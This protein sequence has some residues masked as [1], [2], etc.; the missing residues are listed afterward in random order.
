MAVAT[1]LLFLIKFFIFFGVWV[2]WLLANGLKCFIWCCALLIIP[3]T[4]L[5]MNVQGLSMFGGLSVP[6]L[7]W[8]TRMPH[9]LHWGS[10]LT[11]RFVAQDVNRGVAVEIFS[12]RWHMGDIVANAT[13]HWT[14]GNTLVV[15]VWRQDFGLGERDDRSLRSCL[16]YISS[17]VGVS[18]AWHLAAADVWTCSYS[19]KYLFFVKRRCTYSSFSK[20]WYWIS[21]FIANFNGWGCFKNLVPHRLVFRCQLC[22]KRK[23][24]WQH[25]EPYLLSCFFEVVCD[26]VHKFFISYWF[27]CLNFRQVK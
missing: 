5:F 3:S 17:F 2:G 26:I 27:L 8:E 16:N 21:S 9:L 24:L 25:K 15:L 13:C 14:L 10:E 23:F 1:D 20:R 6:S 19:T 12:P 4:M 11:A 22:H 7:R 18:P